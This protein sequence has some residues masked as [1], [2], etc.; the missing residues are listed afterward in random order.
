MRVLDTVVEMGSYD[1][2]MCHKDNDKEE[3]K[4]YCGLWLTVCI[5]R[6]IQ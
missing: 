1:M 4:C 2:V 6:G 5:T 3:S